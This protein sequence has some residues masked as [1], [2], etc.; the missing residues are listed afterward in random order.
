MPT[1]IHD[2]KSEIHQFFHLRIR[3]NYDNYHPDNRP[4]YL[5]GIKFTCHAGMH[6]GVI[7]TVVILVGGTPAQYGEMPSRPNASTWPSPESHAQPINDLR[8]VDADPAYTRRGH[9]GT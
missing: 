5:E 4:V 9:E 1:P 6:W 8:F 3:T 2:L 7:E